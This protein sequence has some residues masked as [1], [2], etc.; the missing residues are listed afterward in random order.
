MNLLLKSEKGLYT[1]EGALTIV[2]F[3]ALFMMIISII[4]IIQVESEVQSALNETAMQ[5]SNYSYAVMGTVSLDNTEVTELKEVIQSV[6]KDA[7]GTLAGK[8]FGSTL[9]TPKID[10]KVLKQIKNQ[11]INYS[12]SNVL[13]DSKSICLVANYEIK[14][15]TFGLVDKTISVCQKVQTAAWLPYNVDTISGKGGN[16]GSIWNATNFARGKYFVSLL[17]GTDEAA[18]VKSGQGFDL[19]YRDEGRVCEIVSLNIFDSTYSYCNGD[20]SKAENYSPNTENIKERIDKYVYEFEKDIKQSN[21]EIIMEDGSTLK[22]E[23]NKKELL[24]VLPNEANT[25]VLSG[26]LNSLSTA[27]LNK[28]IEI[29]F[30]YSEDAL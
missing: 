20:R 22:L 21:N 12:A 24:I 26:Y 2:I 15:E 3:T 8:T 30:E 28:G 5:L 18:K 11:E 14:V 4:S 7:A 10:E 25:E 9:V 13:G 17:K 6:A 19:Y 27:Y 16:S 23:V 29:R 1:V